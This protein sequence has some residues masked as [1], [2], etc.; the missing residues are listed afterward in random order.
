[1][2]SGINRPGRTWRL[3]IHGTCFNK[4]LYIL[5]IYLF[6]WISKTLNSIVYLYLYLYLEK[7]I[8]SKHLRKI[9]SN[10]RLNFR[11]PIPFSRQFQGPTAFKITFPPFPCWT[12]VERTMLLLQIVKLLVEKAKELVLPGC[13]SRVKGWILHETG[14]HKQPIGT[15]WLDTNKMQDGAAW[16]WLMVGNLFNVCHEMNELCPFHMGFL[17]MVNLQEAGIEH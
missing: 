16:W 2:T 10:L 7:F 5:G 4:L 3:C 9:T 17:L 1:M 6:Q 15:R 11:F 13:L 8:Q 14:K 12:W